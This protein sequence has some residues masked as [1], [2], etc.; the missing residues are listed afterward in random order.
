ML[1]A[2]SAAGPALLT[3]GATEVGAQQAGPRGNLVVTGKSLFDDQRYEES[4][5]TLSAALLRPGT[6]KRERIEIYRYLAYNYLTLSRMEE[7]EAAVRG[8][9]SI[10]PDFVLAA[11]ES[12][13]FRDFFND[14]EKKWQEEGRP[15]LVTEAVAA[16]PVALKH[17]SPAEW[18]KDQAIRVTGEVD[19]TDGRVSSVEVKFRTGSRG[20]F[21]TVKAR[22]RG[23]R[24]RAVLP[25]A[26]AQ[27]PIVEYYI[28]AQDS[29]G[30]PVASRG[31]AF[32]P[33]RIAIPSPDDGGSVF[34]S[35]WFWA[36]SAAVVGGVLAAILLTGKNDSGPSTPQQSGPTSH[37]VVVIG[38]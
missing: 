24:F 13:R 17:A 35:P 34:A 16:S 12:P 26:A 11:S 1:L 15:G 2:L 3:S 22:V 21:S 38:P 23:G 31:D 14:I 8:L 33:L 32:A 9:Y 10:E 19:D 30:L 28:E 36:G 4:I 6:S 27:P 5:Q 37:V 7:A 20:K 18:Q 25:G 29:A